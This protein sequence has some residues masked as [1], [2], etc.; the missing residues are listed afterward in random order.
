MKTYKNLIRESKSKTAVMVF[1]RFNPPTIGHGKLLE[2]A[3]NT[4]RICSLT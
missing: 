3:S 2:S 4:A 1:G